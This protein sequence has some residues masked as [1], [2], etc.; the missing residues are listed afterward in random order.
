MTKAKER[1]GDSL[2]L[3]VQG[4]LNICNA[5]KSEQKWT[6]EWNSLPLITLLRFWICLPEAVK[7]P[8]PLPMCA[9]LSDRTGNR[10]CSVWWAECFPSAQGLA[11]RVRKYWFLIL[12]LCFWPCASYGSV[13]VW[14]LVQES[15]L[16][17]LLSAF[18]SWPLGELFLGL[19]IQYRGRTFCVTSSCEANKGSDL[20]L[21]FVCQVRRMA[22]IH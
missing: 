17:W 20:Y 12:T 5:L 6:R 16:W 13:R 15:A 9:S 21:Q 18:W 8:F 2:H 22:R 4:E 11:V 3:G 7:V 10:G 1:K 14:F 19:V